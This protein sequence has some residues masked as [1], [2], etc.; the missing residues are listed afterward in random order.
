MMG[1]KCGGAQAAWWLMVIGGLN[2]GIL[3]LGYYI[4]K[5]WDWNVLHMIF[6]QWMWLEAL[7]YLVVGICALM[8][9]WGCKCKSCAVEAK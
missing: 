5:S 4:G 3:G 1:K 8:A 9:L 6:G 2:W 7:I